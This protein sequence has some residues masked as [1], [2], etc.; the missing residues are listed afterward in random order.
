MDF[1]TPFLISATIIIL[2]IFVI[3]I[4]ISSISQNL[5]EIILIIFRRMSSH[6]LTKIDEDLSKKLSNHIFSICVDIVLIVVF[7]VKLMERF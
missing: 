6:P 2:D 4:N 5:S 7:L 1:L 3:L